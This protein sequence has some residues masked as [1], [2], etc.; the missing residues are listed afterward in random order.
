MSLPSLAKKSKLYY[1]GFLPL[2]KCEFKLKNK[3][4][5]LRVNLQ[6]TQ[7]FVTRKAHSNFFKVIHKHAS[8]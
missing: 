7:M 8:W 4:R 6:A 2:Q 5:I 3:T 1:Q